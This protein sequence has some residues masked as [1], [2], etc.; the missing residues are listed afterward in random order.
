[1]NH[2]LTQ[3]IKTDLIQVTPSHWQPYVVKF[4]DIKKIVAEQ[5][6]RLSSHPVAYCA[7]SLLNE[8]RHVRLIRYCNLY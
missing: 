3:K 1:M 5:G 7:I 6:A 2:T 4:R 8:E